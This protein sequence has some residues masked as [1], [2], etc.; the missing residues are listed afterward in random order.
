LRSLSQQVP[1]TAAGIAALNPI[2]SAPRGNINL[3]APLST[4]DAGEAGVRSSGNVNLAALQIVNAANI[5]AQGTTTGVP[6]VQAPPVAA[7]TT[8]SN[9]T[10]ATQQ[11]TLP[12]QSG[13]NDRPSIII[14]EVLGYGGGSDTETP[15][16]P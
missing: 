7:R 4:I 14:V 15:A 1:S 11:A 9:A 3:V 5:Q 16:Q 2:P 12:N 10:A 6:V 13:N 8:S